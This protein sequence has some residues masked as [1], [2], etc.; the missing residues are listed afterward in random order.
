M[1]LNDYLESLNM[2]NRV[3]EKQLQESK[4]PVEMSAFDHLG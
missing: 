3:K 1:M 2:K 4:A